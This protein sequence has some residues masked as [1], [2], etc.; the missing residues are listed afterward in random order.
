MWSFFYR[1][2]H[3]HCFFLGG[4]GGSVRTTVKWLRIVALRKISRRKCDC[5]FAF[6]KMPKH[7]LFGLHRL[8]NSNYYYGSEI[9]KNSACQSKQ[10]LIENFAV[11]ID[12]LSSVYFLRI[13]TNI[14]WPEDQKIQHVNQ[15]YRSLMISIQLLSSCHL[16]SFRAF[17]ITRNCIDHAQSFRMLL[18]TRWT[19]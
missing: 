14:F 6:A 17:K 4:G 8:L 11:D 10:A 1:C 7:W 3:F 18:M 16:F 2:S 13:F 9:Q 12:V 5:S 15:I 19:P